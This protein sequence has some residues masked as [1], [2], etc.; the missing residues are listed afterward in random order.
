MHNGK[1]Y[2][3][4]QEADNNIVNAESSRIESSIYS[5]PVSSAM[6][7][8]SYYTWIHILQAVDCIQSRLS[9]ISISCVRATSNECRSHSE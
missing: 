6:V 7:P 9:N 2:M 3:V 8:L 1:A 5:H 4:E